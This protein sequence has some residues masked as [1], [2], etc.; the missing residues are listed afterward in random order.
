MSETLLVLAESAVHDDAARCG[1]AAG[2]RIVRG[3]PA[4]C[5]GDWLRATAVVVDGAALAVLAQVQPPA[6]LGVVVAAGVGADPALWRAGLSVGA[7]GGYVLPDD[8]AAL[9]AALSRLRRPRRSAAAVLALVGGHG[10]VGVSTFAAVLARTASRSETGVLLLDV[11]P[12]GA[13]LDLLLGAEDLPGLRWSDITGETG[14]IQGQALSAALPRVG[15]RLRILTQRRDDGGPLSAET[16]LA[17]V[18]AARSDGGLVIAD[19]GRASDPA[20]AGVLDSADLIAVLTGASVPGVSATRKLLARIGVRS[21][22]R[23]VVRL[24][25]PGG[26]AAEQVAQAVGVPL[27]TTLRSRATL[28]R[29]SEEGGIRAVPRSPEVRAATAVLV[30][31][32][33]LRGGRR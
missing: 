27:V 24:P 13:G 25:A 31:L 16:V 29:S 1:A 28:A 3:D 2:Y 14:S 6:R 18:D 17:V 22:M 33:E 7:Q 9:V 4:H 11:A 32:D 19:L 10:G 5:R 26:L 30:A 21:E 15:D 8:E 23:L 20:A 12:G